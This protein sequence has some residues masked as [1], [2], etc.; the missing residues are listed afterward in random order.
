MAQFVDKWG[1]S[2]AKSRYGSASE[3]IV[4]PSNKE[5]Y[6]QSREDQQG[7]DYNNDTPSNWLRGMPNAEGKPGFDKTRRK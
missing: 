2:T 4:N 7:P 5:C 6:P 1:K 3:S